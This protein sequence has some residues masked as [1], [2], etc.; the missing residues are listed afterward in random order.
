MIGDIPMSDDVP[1]PP[2]EN[3]TLPGEPC[4]YAVSKAEQLLRLLDKVRHSQPH[5]VRPITI[6]AFDEA[7]RFG[8]K[9]GRQQRKR[10]VRGEDGGA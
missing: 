7:A 6:T 8:A 2:P 5:L 3:Q 1:I 9:A 4:D 10:I